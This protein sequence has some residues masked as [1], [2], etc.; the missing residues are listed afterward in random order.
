V[1]NII[2][3]TAWARQARRAVATAAGVSGGLGLLG[4]AAVGLL[5]GQ[6]RMARR[7][8]P[9]A[10][11]PPPRADG[12]YGAELPGEP[13]RMVVLGDSSAAGYGTDRPRDTPAALLAAGLSERIGRPVD[14]RVVAV[15]GSTSAQL[16]PQRE[17]ALEWRPDVAVLLIGAN[18]VT[19]RVPVRVAI[20][21]LA[22]TVALL[23][24]AGAGVVVGTCP[25][26]GTIRP[27]QPPLRWLAHRWSRDM[28]TA[29]TVAVVRAGGATV[30]LGDL[31]GPQFAKSPD[32]LFSSDHFHPSAAGYAAAAAAM[33]PTVV[34][35]MSPAPGTEQALQ[36]GDG[37]RSLAQ[38]AAEAVDRAG[39]EVSV[40]EVAAGA[41]RVRRL[42]RLRHRVRQLTERPHDPEPG[43]SLAK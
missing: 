42:T 40:V 43:P 13:L 9:M 1:D 10:E 8:I 30:S 41:G 35:A 12:R 34:A 36:D 6:A 5:V 28:A 23:R 24:A 22:D 4:V 27:I 2:D 25:D 11:S 39:T 31:L 17:L 18:D 20:G 3:Q 33:L 7:V 37:V 32:E 15:V 19:H 29:Q 14:V 16:V 26:L 21:H 38:A